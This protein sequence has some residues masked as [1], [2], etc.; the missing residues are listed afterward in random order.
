MGATSIIPVDMQNTA[1]VKATSMGEPH[2]T[3]PLPRSLGIVAAE[4]RLRELKRPDQ[5]PRAP[6]ATGA[7]TRQDQKLESEQKAPELK[8]RSTRQSA[9]GI[10]AP[11]HRSTEPRNYDRRECHVGGRERKSRIHRE[12]HVREHRPRE[13]GGH[14]ERDLVSGEA[15]EPETTSRQAKSWNAKSRE[16]WRRERTA[17]DHPSRNP[18]SR[19]TSL[20]RKPIWG[21]RGEDVGV[22]NH[23]ILKD[24][25]PDHMDAPWYVRMWIAAYMRYRGINDNLAANVHYTVKCG[26]KR[27]EAIILGRDVWECVHKQS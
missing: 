25:A 17:K 26:V 5:R 14:K 7:R 1:P 2:P 3:S 12:A 11:V 19:P 13:P 10:S 22:P 20:P 16:P 6:E 23:Q 4:K 9:F 24:K 21:E 27:N 15:K 8:P 18:R